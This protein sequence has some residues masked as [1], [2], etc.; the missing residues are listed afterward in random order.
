M[1]RSNKKQIYYHGTT[2]DNLQEILKNGIKCD[3]NKIWTCSSDE[4][5]L[6]GVN[7]LA[8]FEGM[9]N[10]DLEYKENMA[11]CRASESA[12]IACCKAKDCRLLVFK[13]ELPIAEVTYDDSCP[14]MRRSGAMTICR[15][16][17]PEEIVAI[18]ISNELSL[19]RGYFMGIV[20]DMEY[21]GMTF[22]FSEEKIARA[23]KKAE[24]YP[25]DIEYMIEWNSIP[26]KTMKIA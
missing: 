19:I 11:F 17:H 18:K 23:F 10:D 22:T 26:V 15:D 4:I 16:I 13:I 9:E 2:A 21:F 3:S 5:Y 8:K 12:Q 7:E 24:L 25:E 6:W 14:N 20:M 1:K